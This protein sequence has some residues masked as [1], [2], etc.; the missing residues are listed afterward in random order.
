[1]LLLALGAFGTAAAT[2][3]ST[4]PA[5]T[6]CYQQLSGSSDRQN[7]EQLRL[8][9]SGGRVRGDYRWVPWG[10]DRRIGRLEGRLTAPGTARVL[11][12]F[13]QEGQWNEESLAIVFNPK[14]ARISRDAIPSPGSASPPPLPPVL[15]PQHSCATLQAIPGP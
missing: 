2:A 9:L 3:G 8:V 5:T 13:M 7:L 14:Q 10:K 6:L 15:L 11:H 12:R 1:M 4:T